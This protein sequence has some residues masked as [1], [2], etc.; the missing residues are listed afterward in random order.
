[1]KI[2]IFGGS[3]DPPHIGHETIINKALEQLDIQ[4]LIVVPTFLNPFK[5]QDHLDAKKRLFLLHELF[6]NNSKIDVSN[7]E[8]SKN[9]AVH[10]I[11]TVRHIQQ[12]FNPSKIY[13]IIGADNL[14]KLHLW[15]EFEELEKLV[16]FVVVTRNGILNKNYDRIQTLKV[17]INIS[18]TKLRDNLDLDFIPKKIQKDVKS[19]W[20]KT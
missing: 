7:F 1:M 5:N 18:S 15:K 3:F 13:L 10:S 16:E 4:K 20:Q 17:D 14:E 11:E 6:E 12:L 19:Y 2:A 9:R 8:I